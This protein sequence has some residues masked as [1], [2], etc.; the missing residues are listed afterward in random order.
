[1]NTSDLKH[2]RGLGYR[3]EGEK[4]AKKEPELSPLEKAQA[5]LKAKES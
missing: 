1:M 2:W 4:P 5:D 3:P